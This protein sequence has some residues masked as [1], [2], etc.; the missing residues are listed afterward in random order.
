METIY[1]N[2]NET[3]DEYLIRICENKEKFDLTW[4]RVTELINSQYGRTWSQSTVRKD[5]DEYVR[6]RHFIVEH[7]EDKKI[8]VKLNQLYEQQVLMHDERNEL[9]RLRRED[10]RY[11]NFLHKLDLALREK[12]AIDFPVVE[13]PTK[14]TGG[15]LL[16][17]VSD[18]HYGLKI[19]APNNMYNGT[20]AI[21]RLREYA[22]KIIGAAKRTGYSKLK[23]AL[24]GDL[25]NGGIHVTGRIKNNENVIE[26]IQGVAES[27]AHFVSALT[28][29]FADIEII[30]VPGNHSRFEKKEDALNGERL[31]RLIPWYLQSVFQKQG[32]VFCADPFGFWGDDP[33]DSFAECEIEGKRFWFVHGDYDDFNEQSVYKLASWLNKPLPYACVFAHMHQ[34]RYAYGNILLLSSGCLCG[35]GDEYTNQKRLGGKPS[36]LLCAIT[37]NGLD[38][39]I[40]V[41]F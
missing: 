6:W 26:Q 27:I 5:Y 33:G 15:T 32:N 39:V 16:A 13:Y 28:P 24:L 23:I 29:H 38:E 18:I 36:Q 17:C 21:E 12:S 35:N 41:Q 3:L 2:E 37:E 9:N 4:D 7:G 11:R 30:S 14:T 34:T 8:G 31:D 25:I 20:V 10:A 19:D 1:K 40:P 22:S